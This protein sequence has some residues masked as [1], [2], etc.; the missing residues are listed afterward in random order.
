MNESSPI[1]EAFIIDQ[2]RVIETGSK[3][4]LLAIYKPKNRLDADGLSIFPGFIDSHCH[5]H[6]LA[7][8]LKWIDL[9]G[10]V[11]FN[12]VIEQIANTDSIEHVECITGRGWDQNLWRKKVFPT[13]DKLDELYPDQLVVF[14]RSDGHSVLANQTAL[15]LAGISTDHSFTEGEVEIVDGKLTGRSFSRGLRPH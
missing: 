13:K 3:E 5:F 7:L 12:E 6:G 15:N 2:G 14:V 10:C 11:S 8:G 1:V 4:A 9:V